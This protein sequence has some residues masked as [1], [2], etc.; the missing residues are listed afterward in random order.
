M[1]DTIRANQIHRNRRGE[2][3]VPA[4]FNLLVIEEWIT[5]ILNTSENSQVFDIIGSTSVF[6]DRN[7]YLIRL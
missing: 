2:T 1:D 5:Q 4:G 3:A 6:R 7:D